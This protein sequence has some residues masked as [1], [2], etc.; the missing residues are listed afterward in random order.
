M[1]TV[2]T[3]TLIGDVQYLGCAGA[4]VAE[5]GGGGLH[6][7]LGLVV[8]QSRH[9]ESCIRRV[10]VRS[11]QIYLA[12]QYTMGRRGLGTPPDLLTCVG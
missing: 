10:A 3:G 9:P 11:L 5:H 1:R 7:T 8:A 12:V 4:R 6:L 2:L